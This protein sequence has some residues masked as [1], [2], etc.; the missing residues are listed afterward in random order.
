MKTNDTASM[1]GRIAVFC[2]GVI[3]YAI[4]FATFLYL[5]G[6]IGNVLVPTSIDGPPR[7]GML[8]GL[9]TD[10]GLLGLFAVQHSVMARPAFKR[11]WTRFV[12]Q[13]AERST[14]VLF[15]SLALIVMFAFWEPLGGQVWN[16]EGPVGR[17]LMWIAFAAGWLLVLIATFLINHFDLFGLRQVWLNLVGK[18]YT[19][20]RFATPWLYRRV[21]HPLYVGW[22]FAFWATPTMTLTHLVFALALT[23]YIL[24]AIRYEERDLVAAHGEAYRRYRERVPMLVPRIGKAVRGPGRQPEIA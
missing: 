4:F 17:N 22:L 11:W 5:A 21:R 6:F 12:P 3:C 18:P 15:T 19:A 10:L 24:V 23:A 7:V 1:A 9:I 8:Q 16:L 2:Y 20:L 13:S 14:Y